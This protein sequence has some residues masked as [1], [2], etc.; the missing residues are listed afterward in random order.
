MWLRLFR[1]SL[2]GPPVPICY[3]RFGTSAASQP[4]GDSRFNLVVHGFGSNAAPAAPRLVVF[5]HSAGRLA[6]VGSAPGR[7]F[8]SRQ[9]MGFGFGPAHRR[10]RP[11]TPNKSFKP[12]PL[13]G[14]GNTAATVSASFSNCSRCGSA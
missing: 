1:S 4:R 5:R 14:F 8:R 12:N 10:L 7:G 6:L 9:R 13:R 11:T 3:A 2:P